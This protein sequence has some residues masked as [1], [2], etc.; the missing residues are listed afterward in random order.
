MNWK[1]AAVLLASTCFAQTY[2]L[3]GTL[4]YGVY[5]NGSVS[6]PDGRVT[7]G[8]GNRLTAGVVVTENM[9]EHLSGELRYMYQGGGPFV[10]AVGQKVSISGQS[11]S[12]HYD[13]L[14]HVKK[15]DSRWRPYGAAGFG[16]KY[17]RTT[18]PEPLVQPFPTIV[19]FVNANEVRWLLSVGFGL[20]YRVNRHMVVRGD[21]RDYVSPFP[22]K[23]FVH[24]PGGAN[25]GTFQQFTPMIGASYSF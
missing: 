10:S 7:T 1:L 6:S 23:L 2:E 8:V 24:V 22:H 18:G 21:F 19:T 4:G 14:F 5:R 25:H 13:L 12:V 3:G 15:R 20:S 9:Y 16:I 11:H 17:F